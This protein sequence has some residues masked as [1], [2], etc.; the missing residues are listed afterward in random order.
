MK[1]EKCLMRRSVSILLSLVLILSVFPWNRC[2]LLCASAATQTDI[3]A[4]ARSMLGSTSYNKYE[5]NSKTGKYQYNNYCLT[6]VGD[7]YASVG[8]PFGPYD[9]AQI[10][11]DHLPLNKNR[12]IP[13]GAMIYFSSSSG[14]GHVGIYTGND[15][16]IHANA[17]TRTVQENSVTSYMGSWGAY[18]GWTWGTKTPDG[19]GSYIPPDFLDFGKDFYAYIG[20]QATN[21]W[22]TRKNNN[23][24][25]DRP[26]GTDDQIWHFI[27]HDDGSYSLLGN[28]TYA[29]D[30]SGASNVPGT[31]LQMM[32]Y[33]D[34]AAQRFF[35]YNRNGAYFFRSSYADL[36]F[37]MEP[38]TYNIAMC[39][40]AVNV[41]T[42]KFGL[43]I[44]D[45]N[46]VVPVDLGTTFYARIK[47]PEANRYAQYENTNVCGG[48]DDNS[49]EQYWR[50]IRHA[51]RSYSIVNK[52]SSAVDI[53][54]AAD[55][56]G[57]NLQLVSYVG[58]TAQKFYIYNINQTFVFKCFYANLVFDMDLATF[59]MTMQNPVENNVSQFFT[60]E[61]ETEHQ[62][63]NGV[64][65]RESSCSENGAA[66]YTCLICGAAKTETLEKDANNHVGGTEIRNAKN[67]TCGEDGYTGDTYCLG[68]G[69]ELN[70]GTAIP[71]TGKHM[72]DDG[73]TTITPT[74]GAEGEKT[75]TCQICH[76]KKTEVL[77]K[78][79]HTMKKTE[80]KAETC[81]EAGNMEYYTCSVC[82]KVFSD[83]AGTNEIADVTRKAAG[84]TYGE[85]TLTK[86]ATVSEDGIET[87]TC[88]RCGA[89]ETRLVKKEEA[90]FLLGD[91]N[92]DGKLTAAD[93]RLALRRSVSL[94]TYVEG[95]PE[96]LACDVNRD[97]KV[98]AADARSILRASVG[99]K[100]PKI[101]L[102]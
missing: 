37:D 5:Y 7:V 10:A 88:V 21:Q 46:G 63:D 68:C 28:D 14:N 84:H 4:K 1:M 98:T 6:F 85:W 82:Q 72:W 70:S 31:N 36:C 48:N 45:F 56:A 74:C 94:E 58:N 97:G 96:F 32:P 47:N 12:D 13:I 75:F 17:T 49:P 61:K 16:M 67:A 40:T 55:S 59:N 54:N 39:A 19:V 77:Q 57:A 73:E 92:G 65:I 100:D 89:E 99:L 80:E 62:W 50:F 93:A 38:A 76:N 87:R 60:I 18:L 64:I 29:M 52:N 43:Q 83:A 53:A 101:W 41:E 34:N 42:Q 25:G 8:L 33:V 90:S 24:G 15:M 81:A 86:A 22:I 51:D 20:N 11:A 78:L 27:R 35:I 95:S 91:V 79:P 69:S 3:V 26:A 102:G 23:V 9:S 71:K 30:I 2:F 66:D 44:I